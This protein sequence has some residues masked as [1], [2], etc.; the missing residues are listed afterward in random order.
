MKKVISISLVI[1]ICLCSCSRSLDRQGYVRYVTDEKNGLRKTIA[2]GEWLYSIQ[3][4]PYEY[5]LLLESD[6]DKNSEGVGERKAMLKGT[7]W[8]NISLKVA[9]GTT[10]PMRYNVASQYEYEQRL[11]YFLNEAK[12]Q[13][14]LIYG[15]DT[16][17]PFAYHFENNYNLAPI[18]TMVVGFELP[19][20]I[21]RPEEDMWLSYNDQFF[22][23]G[24]I[25][26]KYTEEVLNSVPTLVN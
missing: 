15:K 14:R 18:E 6:A 17:Y 21:D 4:K 12:Q 23:N 1:M 13:I 9:K 26:A 11:N 19:G 16:V 3:Y 5:I 25:K 20:K 24:I 7:A 8:F 10:S 22:K 2:V